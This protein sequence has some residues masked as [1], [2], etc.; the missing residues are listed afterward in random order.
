VVIYGKLLFKPNDIADIIAK[1]NLNFLSG[2][3]KFAQSILYCILEYPGVVLVETANAEDELSCTLY[4]FPP[5]LY[6]IGGYYLFETNLYDFSGFVVSGVFFMR[7]FL[8]NRSIFGF[9]ASSSSFFSFA[10]GGNIIYYSSIIISSQFLNMRLLS[11]FTNKKLNL[12]SKTKLEIGIT[13]LLGISI[14]SDAICSKAC[15]EVLYIK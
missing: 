3:N 12:L 2:G 15:F 11:V 10:N 5:I 1:V 4:I 13:Y 8:L 7:F 14:T 9:S 6:R